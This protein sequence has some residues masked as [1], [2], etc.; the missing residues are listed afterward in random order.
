M[1]FTLLMWKSAAS[2]SFLTPN[3][4]VASFLLLSRALTCGASNWVHS[5]MNRI[6]HGFSSC[7]RL[8]SE[9]L[10]PVRRET[11]RHEE[12]EREDSTTA[13]IPDAHCVDQ[14]ESLRIR[15]VENV[16]YC[17]ITSYGEEKRNVKVYLTYFP[18]FVKKPILKKFEIPVAYPKES[19]GG[20]AEK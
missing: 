1:S 20:I 3:T 19:K 14:V 13:V 11:F 5:G 18:S 8:D 4:S 16:S 12:R 10:Q 2:L 9:R 15:A 6:E 7:T 17:R